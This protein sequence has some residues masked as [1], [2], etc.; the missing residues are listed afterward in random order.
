VLDAKQISTGPD[1]S[2]A[3]FVYVFGLLRGI[4]ASGEIVTDLMELSKA[5]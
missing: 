5:K 4:T 2:R 1:I 3:D